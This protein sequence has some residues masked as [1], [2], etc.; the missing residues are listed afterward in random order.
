[1]AIT[2]VDVD[3]HKAK[4]SPFS[5]NVDI[6]PILRD[7]CGRCHV[8]NGPAPMSLMTYDTDGG[9]VAWAESMREMLLAGAMPPW[10]ADP[11]GPAVRNSHRLTARELDKLIT[12]ATGGTPHGDLTVKLPEVKLQTGW[13]HGKPDLELPISKPFTL[14]AHVMEGTNEVTVPTNLTEPRWVKAADLLPGQASMVRRAYI[15][16][17]GGPLL[18]IWEPGSDDVDPPKGAAF[19]VP[20]NASLHVKIDYK[21]P[22]Q[23]EQ[24]ALEDKSVIG[25]YF[26]DPPAG[27]K[28]IQTVAIDGPSGEAGAATGNQEFSGKLSVGGKVVALRPM[29]DNAYATVDISAVDASGKAVPLLKL[30]NPRPE[31]PRRYWLVEP[32]AVPAQ[33]TIKVTMTPDDPDIGPLG[34]PESFP[35]QIGLDVVPD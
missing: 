33:S 6:F 10:Y 15:S 18:A 13:T 17:E 24:N 30:R 9:A 34:K 11:T 29:L 23:D 22:W 32:I 12:W 7:K 19:Q 2:P 31:W 28:A 20:A 8:D 26:T 5:Y 16:V 3:A 27:G 1:M 4:T 14:A 25:L 35:L 21:K